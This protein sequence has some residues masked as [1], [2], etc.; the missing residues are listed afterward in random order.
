MIQNLGNIK[1]FVYYNIKQI[2]IDYNIKQTSTTLKI[3]QI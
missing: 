1:D 2:E 3:I